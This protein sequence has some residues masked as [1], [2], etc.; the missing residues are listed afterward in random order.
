V[1]GLDAGTATLVVQDATPVVVGPVTAT[2]TTRS[3]SQ[4]VHV[5]LRVDHVAGRATVEAAVTP[6]FTGAPGSCATASLQPQTLSGAGFFDFA[7]ECTGTGAGTAALGAS[8]EL[9]APGTGALVATVVATS[10][11]VLFQ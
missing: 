2:S 6:S 5:T 4:S 11:S 9:T 8:V 7:W 10:D 3:V 1:P